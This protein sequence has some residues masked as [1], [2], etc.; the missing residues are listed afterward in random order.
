MPNARHPVTD[1]VIETE[2]YTGG[3]GQHDI[4]GHGWAEIDE[5]SI[6]IPVHPRSLIGREAAD[7]AADL[8]PEGGVPV[9]LI[10][11]LD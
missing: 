8:F 1:V 11:I 9:A 2:R 4:I 10:G 5:N 7:A 3:R 6:T